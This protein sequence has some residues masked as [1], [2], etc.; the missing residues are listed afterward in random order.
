MIDLQKK[1]KV[2]LDDDF[3]RFPFSSS[4]KRMST[5]I[6]NAHG[7]DAYDRRLLI[8]GAAEMIT[9]CCDYYIDE[10][11]QQCNMTDTVR[12]QCN[13]VI[14]NYAK[15]ALRLDPDHDRAVQIRDRANK[16]LGL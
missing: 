9:K 8:K 16:R 5:I 3:V 1:H 2:S 10:N 11:G 6:Q 14:T 12:T 13:T 15:K 4:R 7:K